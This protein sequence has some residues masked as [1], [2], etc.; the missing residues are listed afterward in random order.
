MNR[1]GG[2]YDLQ[3][4]I[5]EGS[6]GEVYLGKDIR[7]GTQVAVKLESLSSKSQQLV[8]EAEVYK[9]LA[10]VDG[11]PSLLWHGISGDYNAIVLDLLGPDLD[12]L[13]DHCNRKFTDKTILQFGQSAL[14]VLEQMHSCGYIYRDMKPQNFLVGLGVSG[15]S[16][17]YLLD[18]GLSKSIENVKNKK[19]RGLVGTARYASISAHRGDPPSY[20]D[21]L[22]SLGYMLIYF[23]R[24]ALPWSG[25]KAKTTKEKYAKIANKKMEISLKDLCKGYDQG[26]AQF[27]HTC[28]SIRAGD[29]IDYSKLRGILNGIAKRKQVEFDGV[30]DWSEPQYDDG[31][32]EKAMPDPLAGT[33]RVKSEKSKRRKEKKQREKEMERERRQSMKSGGSSRNRQKSKGI[34]RSKTISNIG[35]SH[36]RNGNLQDFS[37]GLIDNGNNE[38]V[39]QKVKI[40]NSNR[41]GNT[42][43]AYSRE[44]KEDASG[45]VVVSEKHNSALCT[46]L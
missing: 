6:F 39:G 16:D 2:R 25:I 7:S 22:E 12:E 43:T 46:I 20:R 36:I 17:I 24:G 40:S 11:V 9:D 5:S 27:I 13:F 14:S 10:A 21:D 33:L 8:H 38:H 35:H 32:N 23:C 41:H 34:K 4:K 31:G 19:G 45:N 44:N 28:R 18:F 1:I 29:P 30:Y 15:E 3:H 37:R 26:Y 42:A